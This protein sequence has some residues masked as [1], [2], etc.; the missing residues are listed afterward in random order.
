VTLLWSDGCRRLR[1]AEPSGGYGREELAMRMSEF[2]AGSVR[3]DSGSVVARPEEQTS[4]FLSRLEALLPADDDLPAMWRAAVA[5]RTALAGLA[6]ILT[7][8]TRLPDDDADAAWQSIAGIDGGWQDG[9]ARLARKVS[10]HL[11]AGP[12]LA[13][14]AAFLMRRLVLR[15]HVANAASKLPD[16]TF[17]FRWELGRLQFFHHYHPDF[18]RPGNIRAWTLAQLSRDLGYCELLPDG[19]RLTA[20]GE[21]FVRETFGT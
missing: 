15:P 4:H 20:D 10:V 12:T 14:T 7:V 21:T 6:L 18:L 9:L 1:A 19:L 11:G 3:L 13:E 17:L 5:Q 8:L 16:F 2:A